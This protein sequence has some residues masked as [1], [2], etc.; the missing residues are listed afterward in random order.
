M[1]RV[2][3]EGSD[4]LTWALFMATW[5]PGLVS[6]LPGGWVNSSQHPFI[7]FISVLTSYDDSSWA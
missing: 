3:L 4:H 2:L 6:D 1:G 7:N 5:S